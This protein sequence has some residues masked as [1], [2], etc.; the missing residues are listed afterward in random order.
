M[1]PALRARLL[2]DRKSLYNRPYVVNR[3]MR[4][5]EKHGEKGDLRILSNFRPSFL[6]FYSRTARAV[7]R[8]CARAMNR[9][10]DRMEKGAPK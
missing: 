3:I 4:V 9:I 7:A 6:R 1:L 8:D 10:K 5:F 2:D